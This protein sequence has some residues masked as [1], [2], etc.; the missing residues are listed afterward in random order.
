MG[1]TT[2]TRPGAKIRPSGIGAKG[3]GNR[4]DGRF[5]GGGP[6]PGPR[7]PDGGDEFQPEKYR[8]A[9][10]IIVVGVLMLFMSI[11]S[12]CLFRSAWRAPEGQIDPTPWLP[13]WRPRILWFNTGVILASSITLE[14]ARRRLRLE[15]FLAFNRWIALTGVLGLAFLAGQIS[16]WRQFAKQGIYLTTNPHAS[17][18]YLLTGLHAAHLLGGLGALLYVTVRGFKFNFGARQ[19]VAVQATA[20]YWHFMDALWVFL[21]VLLFFWR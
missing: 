5:S 9:V 20:V 8:I 10:W 6:P 13:L 2:V 21:F 12:V 3:N 16:A 1:T 17:Y 4:D 19:D 15:R 14:A 11:S 18:F 7:R